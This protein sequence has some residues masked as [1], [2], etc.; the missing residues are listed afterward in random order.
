MVCSRKNQKCLHHT[1]VIKYLGRVFRKEGRRKNLWL[2]CL[3]R[4]VLAEQ[5]GSLFPPLCIPTFGGV[6]LF[7]AVWESLFWYILVYCSN[8]SDLLKLYNLYNRGIL[9]LYCFL[10]MKK[11]HFVNGILHTNIYP[12]RH[13]K[14]W[15]VEKIPH[16]VLLLS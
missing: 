13:L 15:G 11:Q 7:G 16:L 6:K 10:A 4:L 1:L 5:E 9:V 12:Q 3:R 14:I 2:F 8:I